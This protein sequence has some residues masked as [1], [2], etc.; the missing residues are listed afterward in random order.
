MKRAITQYIF[1][2]ITKKI[3]IL[4]LEKFD[5][6]TEIDS[7]VFNGIWNLE[8]V[9]LPKNLISIEN[10]AFINC[11]KL[12]NVI[13]PDT[14]KIIHYNAFF[15]CNLQKFITSKSL[16]TIESGAFYNNNIEKL[17]LNNKIENI[18]QN[19]FKFNK[20]DTCILPDSIIFVSP[21]FL[22]TQKIDGKPVIICSQEIID[23]YFNN[24]WNK[25][26][27]IYENSLDN[28]INFFNF[29]EINNIIKI[30]ENQISK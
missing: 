21:D 10:S 16:H 14:L 9:I 17:F 8:K 15:S 7:Y 2:K 4:D 13:F 25:D 28:L 23:E 26:Y 1:I 19:A 11:K 30:K 12:S 27:E 24:N 5:K 3:N 29:K 18:G 22:D 20:I 6:I